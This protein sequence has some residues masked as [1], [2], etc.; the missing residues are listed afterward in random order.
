MRARRS[1]SQGLQHPANTGHGL[2]HLRQ[3]GLQHLLR[4]GP[5]AG[6]K[7]I[8]QPALLLQRVDQL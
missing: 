4:L 3:M 6:Q 2:I 7:D 8:G 5:A 1:L